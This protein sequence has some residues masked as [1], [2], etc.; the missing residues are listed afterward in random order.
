VLDHI[1]KYLLRDN[2]RQIGRQIAYQRVRERLRIKQAADHC[3]RRTCVSGVSNVRNTL[4]K[5]YPQAEP[6]PLINVLV[7]PIQHPSCLAD[8]ISDNIALIYSWW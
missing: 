4:M 6:R 5:S 8:E 1:F 2:D 3:H 7:V